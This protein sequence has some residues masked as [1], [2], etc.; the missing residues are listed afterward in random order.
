MK[1]F[2]LL[3]QRL[4]YYSPFII[5]Y[6]FKFFKWIF[7]WSIPYIDRE[8]SFHF[9]IWVPQI[10]KRFFL[11]DFYFHFI[12]QF[13]HKNFKKNIPAIEFAT[14]FYQTKKCSW[15]VFEIKICHITAFLVAIQEQGREGIFTY[16][17]FQKGRS[18]EAGAYYYS[19]PIILYIIFLKKSIAGTAYAPRNFDLK[20]IKKYDII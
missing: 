7:V 5:T 9:F 15:Q 10:K 1:R 14:I 11:I 16:I 4:Y 8:F 3:R 19:P 6:F 18:V 13:C 12:N 17:E 20:I 2:F